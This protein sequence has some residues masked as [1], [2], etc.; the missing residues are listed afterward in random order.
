MSS[1][2]TT[3]REIMAHTVAGAAGLV[4]GP[5]MLAA[6]D[7][8]RQE[9]PH[10][11]L[12]KHDP[13]VSLLCVGGFHLGKPDDPQV[14]VRIVREAIDNGATFMDNAWDYHHGESEKR[15]GRALQDGYREKAFLM[16]KHHGRD[17][18]TAMKQLE[19]SLQR[20][21]TDH[22]DLWQFHEIVYDDDPEMLFAPKG[23]I[24]AADLAK[25]Q[26]KVR[27]IGF[28]GHKKPL[29]HLQ[30]LA[31]GY[32][33]DA[34]QMPLNPFDVHY[35]SFQK[36]VLPVLL[37]RGVAPLAMK[38]RGGG[39]L[40]TSGLVNPEELWR[41]VI[42]LPV[43]TVVSGMESVDLLRDNLRMAREL[44]PMDEQERKQI[45]QRVSAQAEKGENELYKVTRRYDGW[46]GRK[47]HEIS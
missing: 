9:M 29:L 18:K 14:A 32:P 17:K 41:Y 7:T 44:K 40:L 28:T 30:M 22:I 42:S 21:K 36:W 26:G 24:E 16:T 35:R 15:M 39:K 43:T 1:G 38:T 8:G 47:L 37:K 33:F 11:P 3:R 25:K 10:R 27:Y 5:S 23:G 6:A 45:E 20:L 19:D 4:M 12:G 2:S 31:Y 34:V 13:R 46:A